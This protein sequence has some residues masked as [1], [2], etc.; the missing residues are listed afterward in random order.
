MNSTEIVYKK[1]SV[2]Q[3]IKMLTECK[4]ELYDTDC[5]I[6]EAMIKLINA[7]GFSLVEGQDTHIDSKMPET[8]IKELRTQIKDVIA[9]ISGK[10]QILENFI[11]N[12]KDNLGNSVSAFAKQESTKNDSGIGFKVSSI[13]TDNS[14]T[15]IQESDTKQSQNIGIATGIVGAT[16]TGIM[17][18][19][20][21]EDDLEKYINEK[22]EEE[23]KK[24]K[25]D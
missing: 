24:E 2:Q 10:T 21:D 1:E 23:E 14:K 25:Q 4:T 17:I 8:L 12:K 3:A 20:E 15:Q 18:K 22:E 7:K 9:N 6:Y 11:A 19:L 16:A 5:I 13:A